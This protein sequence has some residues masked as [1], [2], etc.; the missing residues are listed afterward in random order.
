MF[1]K[2]AE[3]ISPGRRLERHFGLKSIQPAAMF[4]PVSDC[5]K[6]D[7]AELT[8]ATLFFPAR[9]DTAAYLAIRP[10]RASASAL[11]AFIPPARDD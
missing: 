5:P 11:N 6:G 7:P 8:P 9:R 2:R 3:L 1:W 4:D 10:I